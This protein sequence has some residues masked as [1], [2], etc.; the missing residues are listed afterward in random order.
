MSQENHPSQSIA[1]PEQPLTHQ[2]FSD[3]PY[4]LVITHGPDHLIR[5]CNPATLDIFQ[6]GPE[7]FGKP[8]AEIYPRFAEEGHVQTF[9]YVY[10][11]GE[12]VS[13][14]EVP[15]TNTR[16]G[17]EVRYFDVVVRPYFDE[18]GLITGV[19]SHGVEVTSQVHARHRLEEALRA[20]EDFVSVVSHELRNPL[21]VLALHIATMKLKLLVSE[22]H[23]LVAIRERMAKMEETMESLSG[24]VDRLLDA[25]SMAQSRLR[26]ERTEF[27]LGVVVQHVVDRLSGDEHNC[28]TSINQRGSLWVNCDAARI[29]QV[30]SNLL[31][32]AYK[33]GE[34]RPVEI[35]LEGLN[36]VVRFHVQD[37]GMGI[38]A[39]DQR[40]IFERFEQAEPHPRATFGGFGLGLWICR[41]IV[42]AHGGRI[43]VKSTVGAGS[44]FSVELPR[45]LKLVES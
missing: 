35:R 42:E 27:N 19:I 15:L 38:R 3:L 25:S 22:P 7:I 44:C 45:R 10:Q 41:T 20:R 18:R 5:F 17:D 11:T 2:I 9:T 43:W 30:I 23:P 26:L 1:W 28:E 34:G 32:N 21:N 29:D 4:V 36:G 33:Y 31:A 39:E 40:R 37:H 24:M 8:L 13:R 12:V 14:Q 6:L 16:W